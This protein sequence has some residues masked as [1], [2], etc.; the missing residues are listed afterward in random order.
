MRIRTQLLINIVVFSIILVIIA[1]SVAVTQQQIADLNK[2][3]ASAHTIQ[4]GASDLSY[5]SNN[6]FLYQDNSS[7]SLWEAKFATLSSELASLNST[8]PHDRLFVDNVGT[9]M[10]RLNTVFAGVVSFLSNEARNFSVRELP[11]FQTQWNRMAVQIQALAFDSQQLS[12]SIS[13]QTDQTNLTNVVLTVASLG[14]FGAFFI[15][16][17]L[18][19]FRGTLRSITK[20][21]N[22]ITTIGS[23]DLDYTVEAGKKDEIADI[24]Q[25]VNQMAINLKTVT[26]SK[27]ELE[28]TQASLRESEQ[29]WATTLASIGDAVIA[30]DVFGKVVFLNGVAQKLTGWTLPEASQKPIKTIFNIINEQTQ[31]G[32]EDPVSKVLEKGMVVGLAN[33]TI[34]VRKDGTQIPIDDSGAPIK[35]KDGNTT[36]VVLIFRDITER[37]K[38]EKEIV[39]L[40][41]FPSENPSVVLRVDPMGILLFA[42]PFANDHLKGW[43]IKVGECMPESLR[44]MVADAMASGQKSEFEE[45]LGEE[46]FSF[47][48]VPIVSEGYANIYGR[49]ITKRK[50]AEETLLQAQSKLQKY[51]ANLESLVEERTRQL[52]DSERLAAIGA[53]AGMV[54]HDIRNPLQA[55]TSDIYLAKVELASTPEGECKNNALESLGEIEKN[56]SYINKIVQ[57]LQDYA[58]PIKPVAK[59]TNLQTLI[60]ELVKKNGIPERVKVVVKV[61]KAAA[62]VITDSEVVRRVLGNLVNNAV[63][64]MPDG[65]KLNIGAAKEANEIVITVQDTGVGIDEKSRVKL[66]TPLFTTKSKGQGFGLAVVKRMTEAMGGTVTFESEIGKGTKFIIRLPTP[67]S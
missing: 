17:Y 58:R 21:K 56:V 12:Q 8:A 7:L 66:F 49:R 50:E 30:T 51:A 39:S 62:N 10:D 5:I 9:D 29:R 15:T 64:A 28:R 40:A 23:G 2:R 36:G 52:K 67:K 27:T 57:D 65:G 59:E 34:L 48:V 31:L 37:R 26:A 25:S 60:E 43:Q 18:I 11:I 46:I 63:Q 35:D 55:I 45:N 22:G 61:E 13:D 38:V 47:I 41:K 6:Y 24:S 16:S 14:L 54:G 44:Q 53:T 19:T 1:T 20:L 33:H 3:E 42:N 32:V 4:T